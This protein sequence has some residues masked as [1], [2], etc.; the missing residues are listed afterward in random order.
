[1]NFIK[2]PLP[3]LIE[4]YEKEENELRK[5][6]LNILILSQAIKAKTYRDL[7]LQL[8]LQTEHSQGRVSYLLT[9]YRKYGL[10]IYLGLQKR[11]NQNTS[12]SP[13]KINNQVILPFD[14][15][16][17]LDE[18]FFDA[19]ESEQIFNTLLK[20]IA[21]RHDTIKHFGKEIPLPRLTAWYGDEGKVY[22]YSKIRMEPLDWTP[23]LLEI[24]NRIEKISNCTFN[25][26][27]INQYRDGRDSM[28]WHS[29]DE[30]ELGE[31]PI[32]AS[33]SFGAT[34]QFMLKHK[35]RK[36]I[37]SI[38]IDLSS[39]SVLLMKDKSQECWLHQI[40][41]T[42]KPVSTRINLTFRTIVD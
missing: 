27:L 9:T 11:P 29:D 26:V 22:T 28:G 32:I 16:V 23:Q 15:Q 42:T 38:T 12:K 8:A 5:Q 14:G 25:S 6:K 1:K 21:W 41:K 39:G 40:P 30:K 33:V 35:T 18:N 17:F 37:K 34:R 4:M 3:L 7:I 36:D 24:K 13:A 19:K 2:E 31:N 10:E 20:E